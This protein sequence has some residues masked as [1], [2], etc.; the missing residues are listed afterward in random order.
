MKI[1]LPGSSTLFFSS[2][3]GHDSAAKTTEQCNTNLQFFCLTSQIDSKFC[4]FSR[5]CNNERKNVDWILCKKSNKQM[6]GKFDLVVIV[7][8]DNLIKKMIIVTWL[9]KHISFF[10]NFKLGMLHFDKAS[11]Y[12]GLLIKLF[13]QN[14]WNRIEEIFKCG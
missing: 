9:S 10:N 7:K 3:T 5:Q 12:K 2:W 6:K 13:N 4:V 11:R 8:I 14:F 1:Y